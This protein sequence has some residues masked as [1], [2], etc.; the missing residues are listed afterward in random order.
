MLK[1]KEFSVV[2]R[3][4]DI[5][6]VHSPVENR[7]S[8]DYRLLNFL[9]CTV[10]KKI[11]YNTGHN[12]ELTSVSHACVFLSCLQKNNTKGVKLLLS[13]TLAGCPNPQL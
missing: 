12:L 7:C 4:V 9:S 11:M 3:A 5:L 13:F 6:T 2:L 10:T 1:E 8:Q